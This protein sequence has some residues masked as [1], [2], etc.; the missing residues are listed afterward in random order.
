MFLNRSSLYFFLLAYNKTNRTEIV[1][2]GILI[3]P[4]K[5][6]KFR[7][8]KPTSP[9]NRS[10]LSSSWAVLRGLFFDNKSEDLI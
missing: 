4:E 7:R 8:K 10:V 3:P 1:Q 9:L 6:P 2:S 5:P